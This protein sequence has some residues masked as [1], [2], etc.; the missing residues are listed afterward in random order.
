VNLGIRI[1][2]AT[3]PTEAHN[4]SCVYACR[5]SGCELGNL[6]EAVDHCER[7]IKRRESLGTVVEE[8]T[9]LVTLCKPEQEITLRSLLLRAAAGM[10]AGRDLTD[11][12]RGVAE[13]IRSLPGEK[14]ADLVGDLFRVMASARIMPETEGCA[15]LVNAIV[16]RCPAER[17]AALLADYPGPAA[18]FPELLT[19]I[20]G[21]VAERI[22]EV[23]AEWG[24]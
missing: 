14:A 9:R 16:A 5:L 2:R 21:D 3:L 10:S 4:D 12:L 19:G 6:P 15:E 18:V 22:A 20:S 17:L 11:A 7:L 24:R 13:T 1:L 8:V 23:L